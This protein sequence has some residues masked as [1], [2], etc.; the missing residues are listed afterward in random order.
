MLFLL[1]TIYNIITGLNLIF[2]IKLIIYY[3]FFFRVNEN[4]FLPF[5]TS[6][7]PGWIC[8]AEKTHGNFILPYISQVKSP[9]QIMGTLVKNH[10]AKKVD[11]SPGNIYLMSIM[12]CFDKKLEASREDFFNDIYKSRDVDLVITTLEIE[13]IFQEKSIDFQSLPHSKL[14]EELSLINGDGHL[15]G[16]AGSS[17]GGYLEHVYK[18]TANV[19]YNQNHDI[20]QPLQYK[21][22]RN[23]DF[24]ETVLTVNGEEKLRFAFAFGFRNIQN[25]VQKIKRDKCKYHFIEIMACPSGCVNGGG[26]IRDDTKETAKGLLADTEKL[27][28]SVPVIDP[29][30]ET[31]IYELHN[32]LI[33]SPFINN[34]QNQSL[35]TAYHEVEKKV[36]ALNIKW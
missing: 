21:T 29:R 22:L 10:F 24:Q 32:I 8:Y 15:L 26:Q 33:D 35:R 12:P 17:S 11:K 5:M 36:T 27:Y 34:K 19:L 9:Q 20:K 31:R 14:D 3:F 1:K 4:S 18:N 30:M 25:I 23:K 28:Q 6:S 16:L 7:C 13:A 2:E